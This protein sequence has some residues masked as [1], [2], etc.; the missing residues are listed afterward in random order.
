MVLVRNETPEIQGEVTNIQSSNTLHRTE[1]SLTETQ[2]FNSEGKIQG[3]AAVRNPQWVPPR[4][5]EQNKQRARRRREERKREREKKREDNKQANEPGRTPLTM[6]RRIPWRQKMRSVRSWT[7]SS[8]VE[9]LGWAPKC[10]S[11]EKRFTM[12]SITVFQLEGL[13][14]VTQ[15]RV[16]WDQGCPG[17]GK[18]LSRPAGGKLED[19]F[20]AQ[21]EQEEKYSLASFISVGHQKRCYRKVKG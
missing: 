20:C 4:W 19:L 21:I 5:R 9:G 17:V 14:P 18:C 2:A 1:Q 15:L 12:V 7:M 13:R 6:S 3:G 8:A 16:M 10:A 11:F